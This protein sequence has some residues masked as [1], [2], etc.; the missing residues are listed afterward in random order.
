MK[1]EL[2]QLIT[3][4]KKLNLVPSADLKLPFLIK[5]VSPKCPKFTKLLLPFG[6]VYINNKLLVG[7]EPIQHVFIWEPKHGIFYLDNQNQMCFQ[8]IEDLPFAPTKQLFHLHVE[9][10]RH[11]ELE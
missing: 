4:A 6:I 1:L 7:V 2:Q 11:K 10:I 5:H 9:C 8:R 3:K